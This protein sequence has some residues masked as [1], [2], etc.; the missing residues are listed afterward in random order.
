MM[1]RKYK[2]KEFLL[3]NFIPIYLFILFVIVYVVAGIA[4]G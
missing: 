1:Q 4:K 2:L 3:K